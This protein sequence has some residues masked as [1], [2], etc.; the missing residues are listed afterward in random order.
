MTVS[1]CEGAGEVFS[2]QSAPT[3][4]SKCNSLNGRES[5]SNVEILDSGESSYFNQDVYLTVSGQ[6]HLEAVCN[7]IS[8]VYNFSPAFRAEHGR[9]RRHLSEFWM[10]EAEVGFAYD[11]KSDVIDLT[12]SL[13]K[14]VI[15][16]VLKSNYDDLESFVKLNQEN[17][18]S[19]HTTNLELLN[20]IGDV[21]KPYVIMSYKEA[22]EILNKNQNEFQSKPK[23]GHSFGN[24]HE[25]FLVEKYCNN[26][27]VY[28]IDWP[29]S[30]KPFY[31]RLLNSDGN[32]NTSEELVSAVDL[33]FPKIGEL[34]GGAL[35]E[36]RENILLQRMKE[37][38][39]D[40][41]K[42]QD[43]MQWY[44]DLRSVGGA[45]P[46]GGFGVGFDRLIQFI[47]GINNIRDT[48]PFPRTPHK[49]RL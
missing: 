10:I 45:A 29:K 33:L 25:L 47:L 2:V 31:S 15:S 37:C 20:S 22:M 26:V 40:N 30:T 27:P 7:G 32:Q 41:D 21:H 46:S 44:L 48:M 49:C 35:R 6:L 11:L 1:D 16:S 42:L 43:A 5:S 24:E 4:V 28:V 12:E 8:R 19:K 17:N 18:L 3:A 36:F 39:T 13:I 9:S 23:F 38:A 34:C 14:H